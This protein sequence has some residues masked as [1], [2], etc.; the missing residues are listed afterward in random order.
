V[1][2]ATV[3]GQSP[4]GLPGRIGGLT[5]AEALPLQAMAWKT[6]QQRGP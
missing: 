1:F 4:E 5:D 3:Y 2:Y 6:V